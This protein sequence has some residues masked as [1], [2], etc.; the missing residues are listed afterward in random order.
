MQPAASDRTTMLSPGQS[1]GSILAPKTR[2]RKVPVDFNTEV[3]S[4]K[5][6]L[7]Q[8]EALGRTEPPSGVVPWAID[9]LFLNLP[10][11]VQLPLLSLPQANAV[12]SNVSSYSK[13]GLT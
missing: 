13:S 9:Q 7:R 10:L 12:V 1:A 8:L 3:A 2:S 4:S 6:A 5:R 11:V